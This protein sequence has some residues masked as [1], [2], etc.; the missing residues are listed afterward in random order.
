MDY[1]LGVFCFLMFLHE[2]LTLL[3]VIEREARE[4]R[5]NPNDPTANPQ[6]SNYYE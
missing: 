1:I 3:D 6:E 2:A 4:R 5:Q